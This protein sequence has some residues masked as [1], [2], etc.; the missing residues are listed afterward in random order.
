MHDHSRFQHDIDDVTGVSLSLSLSTIIGSAEALPILCV[1]DFCEREIY[2]DFL[3]Y[4]LQPVAQSTIC[5]EPPTHLR[6][7]PV[8]HFVGIARFLSIPTCTFSVRKIGTVGSS[9][10][11]SELVC[12]DG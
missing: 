2:L 3:R 5:R 7:L 11:R 4:V 8:R 1:S 9:C 10:A 12:D 6:L